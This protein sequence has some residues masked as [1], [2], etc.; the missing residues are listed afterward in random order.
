MLTSSELIQSVKRKANIP[1]RQE[2]YTDQDILKIATEELQLK[3]SAQIISVN[4]QYMLFGHIQSISDGGTYFRISERALGNKLLD[5]QILQPDGTFRPCVRILPEARANYPRRK[6]EYIIFN[7]FLEF[8]V[9]L[10]TADGS[11]LKQLIYVRPAELVNKSSIATIIDTDNYTV[12]VDKIPNEFQ[13]NSKIDVYD[14]RS[15]FNMLSDQNQIIGIDRDTATLT[16]SSEGTSIQQFKTDKYVSLNGESHVPQIPGELH[17]LLAQ[18]TACRILAA[19][20]DVEGL[21]RAE[22]EKK[23]MMD[24][25]GIITDNR[26]TGSPIKIVNRQSLLRNRGSY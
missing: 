16:L 8:S 20:N 13:V 5:V 1:E 17:Y 15:P 4:E 19:Q 25:V 10:T 26:V 6:Y 14:N 18:M 2:T 24:A 22:A 12:T 21:S 3:L 23:D 7:G 11:E 9:P